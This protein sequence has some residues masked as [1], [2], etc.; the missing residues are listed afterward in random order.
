MAVNVN[1]PADKLIYTEDMHAFRM[2]NNYLYL[3]H[4]DQFIVLPAYADDVS[5]TTS[6]DFASSKPLSR[7][8]PI[9]SYQNS[10]PRR[11]QIQ[12]TLHREMMTQINYTANNIIAMNGGD[13][14]V[15]YL[16]KQIQAC[17]LPSYAVALKMVNPP[18]V[19]LRMGEDIFIKGVLTDSLGLTYKTPIL[20]NGKYAVVELNLG[21]QE[22]DPYDAMDV[23]KSGSY[24][25]TAVGN[26]STTLERRSY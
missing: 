10:G 11:V 25:S 5:D 12:L 21:I 18:I 17:T 16:I 22:I 14:Y 9:F 24:R 8:A 2:I 1:R 7:S 13:D 3:Y 20:A 26:L 6:V 23:M 4:V 19:A 15:D